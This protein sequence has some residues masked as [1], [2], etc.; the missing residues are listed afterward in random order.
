[1]GDAVTDEK[2]KVGK[3]A[4]RRG[5]HEVSRTVQF[6]GLLIAAIVGFNLLLYWE[7]GS[8]LALLVAGIA[9][10]SLVGWLLYARRVLRDL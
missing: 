7:R 5:R 6:F 3:D 2:N 9:A 10:V 8:R 1:V 4:D